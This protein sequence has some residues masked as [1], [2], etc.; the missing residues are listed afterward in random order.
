MVFVKSDG[1][2]S[3][4]VRGRETEWQIANVWA[5]PNGQERTK[6]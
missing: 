2:G 5:G 6:I 4:L 3:Y 1:A